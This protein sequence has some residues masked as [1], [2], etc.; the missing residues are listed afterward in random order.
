MKARQVKKARKRETKRRLGKKNNYRKPP[1]KGPAA[2]E[3]VH[4]DNSSDLA[5]RSCAA[6]KTNKKAPKKARKTR[7]GLVIPTT[8]EDGPEDD[9]EDLFTW[10]KAPAKTR[11]TKKGGLGGKPPARHSTWEVPESSEDNAPD[12]PSVRVMRTKRVVISE[13]DEEGQD[14][15]EE[16]EVDGEEEDKA[17][18]EE[19]DEVDELEEDDE[20]EYMDVDVDDDDAMVL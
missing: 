13:E 9:S 6:K 20:L 14:E 2:L 19:E 7:K 10:K 5:N 3:E 15:E 8:S 18:E 1:Q 11:K 12:L 16:D 4:Q 17:D